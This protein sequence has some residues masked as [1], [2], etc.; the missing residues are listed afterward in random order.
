[1]RKSPGTVL[2]SIWGPVVP[3]VH[4]AFVRRRGEDG[5]EYQ[6]LVAD[7]K[8]ARRLAFGPGE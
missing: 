8:H 7:F 6:M 3:T 1:M 4:P 5:L 2:P